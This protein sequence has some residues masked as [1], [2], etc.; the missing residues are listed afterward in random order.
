MAEQSFFDYSSSNG[1]FQVFTQLNTEYNFGETEASF[2]NDSLRL[3][4]GIFLS[5]FP[6]QNFTVLGLIQH[7]SLIVINNNFSQNYTA[8]GAGL[9][10]QISRT[11][12][13]ETIYTNL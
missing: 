8:I 9:K 7:S 10:Y 1:N 13:I 3:S 11:L 2:A 4:P 6:N 12:N 5:Y